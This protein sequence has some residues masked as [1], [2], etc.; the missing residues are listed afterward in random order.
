VSPRDWQERNRR[1]RELGFRNEY[2]RR[3]HGKEG[4]ALRAARGHAGPADLEDALRSGRVAI[5]TQEPYG[6]RNAQG[7]YEEVRVTVQMVDGS[8]RRYRLHGDQLT[9][10]AL[11]PLRD[12]ASASGTDVYSNPSLDVLLLVDDDLDSVEYEDVDV[13]IWEGDE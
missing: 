6:E 7:Q 12:A 4:D 11:A 1:A 8:Q 5:M 3:T 10:E 9:D 2:D 13:E